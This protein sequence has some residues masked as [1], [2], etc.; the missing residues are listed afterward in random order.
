MKKIFYILLTLLSILILLLFNDKS[1]SYFS[2][3]VTI[4]QKNFVKKYFFPHREISEKNKKIFKLERDVFNLE[5]GISKLPLAKLELDFK[6][7]LTDLKIKKL[8]DIKLTDGYSM[9][10]FELMNGL[11]YSINGAIVPGTG[12]L[13]FHKDNLLILSSRGILAYSK[14]IFNQNNF[15]QIRNNI[16]NFIGL[17]QFKKSFKFSIKDLLVYRNFI[18][19]SFTEEI[20]VNCWN[21]SVIYGKM[22]YDDIEFKKLFS[23]SECVH[24]EENPDGEFEAHQSGGRIVPINDNKILLTI[25]DYRSRFL[26]QDKNSVNGKIISIDINNGNYNIVTMGHRNPQGLL[27][28]QEANIILETEHGPWG[29]DEINLIEI[30]KMEENKIQNYG[31]AISSAG[32]HYDHYSDT[33]ESNNKKIKYPLYNSHSDHGFIEPL[34]SFVPSIGISE[35]IKIR[36]NNYA[37]ASMKDK[38]I[39]YFELQNNKIENI[40]RV[41]VFERIRDMLIHKNKIFLLLED[42][43]SIGVINL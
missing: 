24:S 37:V 40:T 22:N 9:S 8:E 29:G 10:K 13:D 12:Y 6:K 15:F 31:W 34:K 33:N 26:A 27:V 36:K 4:D 21:T 23:S 7:N 14:D 41:E 19:V 38:S 25:G 20:K 5:N 16:N 2:S 43:A 39:Y 18:F 3:L 17:N 1:R 30:D 42:S 28:D 35:I 11:Y 32:K